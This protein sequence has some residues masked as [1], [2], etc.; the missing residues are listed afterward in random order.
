[1]NVL[2]IGSGGREHALSWK[3]KQSP[4]LQKLFVVPGNAGTEQIASNVSLDVTNHK[5]VIDFC[6]KE[7]I[8]LVVVGPEVPLVQGIADSLRKAG[9]NVFGPSKQAALIEGEKS[10]AK[11][12]MSEY[13]IPTA[14]YKVFYKSD[15]EKILDYLS[16]SNYP[17]VLKVSGLAAGKGVVI[18]K[19]FDEA[20]ETIHEVIE[21]G[22]F[23]E[24]AEKIVIEEFLE[25]EEASVF[26]ITDGKEYFFLT[27][28]QDHKRIYD[29]D[30]GP[31]TGGMGAYAPAPVVT[32]EVLKKV[33]IKIV[34]PVLNALQEKAGGFVGCLY[35]GLMIH[36][37]EPKV[38]EFNCRFGDPETQVV[39]PLVE[40]DFLEVLYSAAVG[41][42][43]K[44]AVKLKNAT[45]VCVVAASAGYP[46]A[47]KKGFEITGLEEAEK[48]GALIFHA[49]TKAENGKILTNGGRV[50]CV[51]SVVEN[52]DLTYC[53]EKSYEAL[54]KT[55][56]NGIYYR[57][58]IADKGIKRLKA[59]E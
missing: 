22:R 14:A 39:L 35:V 40:G 48:E 33:E 51:T 10:F 25:G 49:G 6:R 2:V 47:Y 31:N 30:E 52:N 15:K 53:K 58:D 12:L 37:N 18:C 20:K 23:G 16:K 27:P 26:V 7:E 32:P 3:I 11:D 57:K 41:H 8:A 5:A 29:N 28:A 42:L 45:A 21:K 24:A 56:F 1:M 4:K 36:E 43:N 34:V 59:G 19:N 17:V 9:V 38:V 50:L 46:G 44:E 13:G 54:A 55:N